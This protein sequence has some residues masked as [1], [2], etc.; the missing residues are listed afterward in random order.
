MA[1]NQ[2]IVESTEEQTGTSGEVA[3]VVGVEYGTSQ[4]DVFS[5]RGGAFSNRVYAFSLLLLTIFSLFLS[6]HLLEPFLHTFILGIVV[7]ASSYPLYSW[8][9]RHMGNRNPALASFFVL[10][11]LCLCIVLPLC[12]FIGGLI[13][14]VEQSVS[15]LNSWL[16]DVDFDRLLKENNLE[17]YIAWLRAHLPFLQLDIAGLRQELIGYLRTLGQGA[18]ESSAYVLANMLALGF[19]FFLMLLIVFFMLKDGKTMLSTLKFLCPLH[20]DQE[21]AILENLRSVSRSVLVGGLLVAALQGVVGGIG[22]ALVGIPALFWGTVMGFASLVPVV[23]TGL[24]WLPACLYLA[25]MGE[26][27]ASLFLFGWSAVL[28][29]S[30]DSFLRPY[31][32]RGGAGMSTFFI[33]MSIIGGMNVF[34]MVGVLY[35]PVILSF[36][37]VMLRLYSEEF[38]DV[39]SH[40]ASTR[41]VKGPHPDTASE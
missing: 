23:G 13:P 29:A 41:K 17:P 25:I 38:S 9:L 4:A 35:G 30:I 20:E 27:K 39:L 7:A 26:W 31:F 10:I 22:L 3:T 24:V 21:D 1:Q 37:M 14:Q 36:A 11:F 8:L 28:V 16:K 5:A 19:Q 32:M 18:L 6:Y 2:D 15:M 12:V 34:G 33:F 40:Q